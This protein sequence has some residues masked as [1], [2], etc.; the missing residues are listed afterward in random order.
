MSTEQKIYSSKDF[1]KTKA[2]IEVNIPDRLIHKNVT[3]AKVDA[4]F[5][6]DR[7]HPVHIVDLPTRAVSMTI[8]GIDPGDRTRNHR[9]T[10]ETIIYVLRGRGHSVVEGRRL[11]W[12]AGDALL[13]P[14]WAWHQHF[15]DSDTEYAEYIGC[16]NAPMLQNIGLALREEES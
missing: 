10:Y 12:E 2:E 6:S 8:G 4:E 5:S 3:G 14:R 1:G 16:E 7:R 13:V 15:N 11:D 9:H